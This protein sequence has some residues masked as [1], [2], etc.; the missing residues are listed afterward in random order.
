[1]AWRKYIRLAEGHWRFLALLVLAMIAVAAA[2]PVLL[3]VER[4]N[5]L[6]LPAPAGPYP[7]GRWITAWTDE[8]RLETLGG[9]P[10]QHRMLSVWTWYPAEPGGSSVP[11]MPPEWAR[12]READRGIGALLFQATDSIRGHATDAEVAS[13]GQPFPV[14][15]FEP[16]L[17]P[18]IP[19][20]T[21]LA[22]DLASRGYVVIGLNPTYS[23]S[24]A[25][26]DGH[27]VEGTAAGTIADNAT[28]EE[29]QQRGDE[30]VAVWA[31]DDRFAID[32]AIRINGDPGSPFAGRLDTH[33][34]GLLGHSFGGAA[35]LEACH[36][37]ARCSAT[38]DLDGSPFGSVVGTGL[39]QPTLLMLSEP[40][41]KANTPAMQKASHDLASI[42][43]MSPQ[44]YQVT[45]EGTRHFNFTDFAAEFDPLGRPLGI[46]GSIG[47]VRGLHI[48]SAY[49]AAFFDQTLKGEPS[50]L[51]QGP[52]TDYPEA[53]LVAH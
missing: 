26:L 22:E 37:D 23:A 41:S 36:L 20:Y 15:V 18:L 46:F 52:S 17:G 24:I 32:Q 49:L 8:L 40:G 12:A 27:V 30:L 38:A 35:A 10:G 45:I 3:V 11:Y 7:V 48:V 31:A 1:M 42:L 19:E 9:P 6:V 25:V 16:G 13:Q 29:F 34:I 4:N 43:D 28:A 39:D 33:R 2:V 14:L 5:E 21:T 53:H 50:P 47:G 51:L 44:S